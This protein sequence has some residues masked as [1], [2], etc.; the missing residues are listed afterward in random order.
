MI[1]SIDE[2]HFPHTVHITGRDYTKKCLNSK[3]IVTTIFSGTAGYTLES[4]ISALAA[5]SGATKQILPAQA[6]TSPRTSQVSLVRLA[7]RS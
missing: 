1:D 5:N 7:G 3:F 2:Q 6:S 4:I